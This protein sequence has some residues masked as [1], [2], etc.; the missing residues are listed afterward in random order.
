MERVEKVDQQWFQIEEANTFIEP[1][2]SDIL[3]VGHLTM[4]ITFCT[5]CPF[6]IQ[7]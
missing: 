6:L 1:L 7:C 3:V 4:R 2:D 5:Y